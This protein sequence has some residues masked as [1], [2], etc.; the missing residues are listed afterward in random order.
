MNILDPLWFTTWAE[1]RNDYSPVIIW[2]RLWTQ[3]NIEGKSF[4]SH[5]GQPIRRSAAG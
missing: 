1:Q 4:R 5:M 3:R 2:N